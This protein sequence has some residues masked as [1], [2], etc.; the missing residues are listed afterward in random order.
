MDTQCYGTKDLPVQ[1]SFREIHRSWNPFS[2]KQCWYLA[3][4]NA[5]HFNVFGTVYDLY[6]H[7]ILLP[8]HQLMRS[9]Y[10]SSKWQASHSFQSLFQ[11]N[12]SSRLDN[13]QASR[14]IWSHSHEVRT[15]PMQFKAFLNESRWSHRLSQHN[16]QHSYKDLI[17]HHWVKSLFHHKLQRQ[18]Q[19][20]IFKLHINLNLREQVWSNFWSKWIWF[21]YQS[22]RLKTFDP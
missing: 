9:G 1:V 22:I 11:C 21:W 5:S 10:G 4:S 7:R 15:F 17:E 14:V 3:K 6:V 19:V 18:S 12:F 2:S 8:F 13:S 20:S 16:T